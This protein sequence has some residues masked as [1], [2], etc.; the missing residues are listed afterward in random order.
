MG[1]IFISILKCRIVMR[2]IS[3][4]DAITDM[5]HVMIIGTYV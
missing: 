4:I 2:I 5:I 3:I 1:I